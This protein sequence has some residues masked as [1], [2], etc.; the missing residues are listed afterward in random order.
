MCV[1]SNINQLVTGGQA[2]DCPSQFYTCQIMKDGPEVDARCAPKVGMIA[3]SVLG[4]LLFVTLI[5]L[6]VSYFLNCM[7]FSQRRR[8]VNMEQPQTILITKPHNGVVAYA[9]A[10]KA[11]YEAPVPLPV[12]TA[13]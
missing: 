8:H 7:C 4:S 10:Q 11:P 5:M 9:F 6:L 1:C 12:P 13:V 2:L 3:A